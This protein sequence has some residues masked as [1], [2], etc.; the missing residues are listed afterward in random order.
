MDMGY[1]IDYSSGKQPPNRK[2]P[3]RKL[4]LT[5]ALFCLFLAGVYRF[6][7]DGTR[8][9]DRLLSVEGWESARQ[10]LE[11]LAFNLRNGSPLSDAIKVFC[12]DLIHNG[13]E[14]AA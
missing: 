13:L 4:L 14:Y 1:Q 3:F 12:L 11:I 8:V 7:P 5:A 9:L 10:S 2:G 6:W